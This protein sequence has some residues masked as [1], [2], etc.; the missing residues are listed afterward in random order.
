MVVKYFHR[1]RALATGLALSG[2][3]LGDMLMPRLSRYL[4]DT[5]GL[6]GAL[7]LYAGVVL[8]ICV[9]G[10]VY[11]PVSTN[12]QR[13]S[14]VE[15][16][17]DNDI[18]EKK[19]SES[20][21]PHGTIT[22]SCRAC[23]PCCNKD[24]SQVKP[25]LDFTVFRNHQFVALF[26]GTIVGL[27]AY[28]CVYLFF[29]LYCANIGLSNR[30]VSD[31]LAIAG[32]LSLIGRILIGWFADF[33]WIKPHFLFAHCAFVCGTAVIVT[34][35][36]PSVYSSGVMMGIVGFFG[37]GYVALWGIG[38]VE[39]VGKEKMPESMGMMVFAMGIFD[40]AEPPIIGKHFIISREHHDI[41]NSTN[42]IDCSTACSDWQQM[43]HTSFT[44]LVLCEGDPWWRHQ[45]EP[46]SA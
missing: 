21:K 7:M 13:Y 33:R 34:V 44:F 40:M 18:D 10:A 17:F 38:I 29:P 30:N 1:R 14:A 19:P 41:S 11:R 37:G 15:R 36:F 23:F 43:E 31:I 24:I 12:T 45:M 32:G 20:A 22:E 3:S 8:Q 25:F 2:G 39:V 46:F 28:I 5:Y 9:A 35:W 26:I 16:H 27:P 6:R 4:N 42:T